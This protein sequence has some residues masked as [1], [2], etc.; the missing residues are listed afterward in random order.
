MT[1][2]V[3]PGLN[4]LA[5]YLVNN[6]VLN[7]YLISLLLSLYIYYIYLMYVAYVYAV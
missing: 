5:C 6:I 4:K 7:E 2:I 3:G 1:I